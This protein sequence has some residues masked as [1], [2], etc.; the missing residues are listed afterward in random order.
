VGKRYAKP[1]LEL[2]VAMRKVEGKCNTCISELTCG[3]NEKDDYKRYVGWIMNKV[4][5]TIRVSRAREKMWRRWKLNTYTQ[6]RKR[7]G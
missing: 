6:R 3:T 2:F 1:T 4:S 7:S 5:D